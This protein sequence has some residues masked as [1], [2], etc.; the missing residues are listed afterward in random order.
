[1]LYYLRKT[2]NMLINI[3]LY[4]RATHKLLNVFLFWLP[5]LDS[6]YLSRLFQTWVK[7]SQVTYSNHLKALI[8]KL[9]IV[10]FRNI[11]YLV[12]TK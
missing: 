1:M 7:F 6:N 8:F 4:L 2:F 10:S 5:K 11:F 12:S 3:A 9:N